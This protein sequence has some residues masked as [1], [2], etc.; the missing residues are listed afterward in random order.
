MLFDEVPLF[1]KAAMFG[2]YV[3]NIVASPAMVLSVILVLDP[4]Q[5]ASSQ[6]L[7]MQQTESLEAFLW[8][9]IGH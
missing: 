3:V 5:C 2:E 7:R 8:L 6:S 9:A 4:R 1:L